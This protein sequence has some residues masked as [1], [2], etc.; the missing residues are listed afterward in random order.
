MQ[1]LEGSAGGAVP[2]VRVPRGAVRRVLAA[3]AGVCY[4]QCSWARAVVQCCCSPPVVPQD[5]AG[6]CVYISQCRTFSAPL[7]L[8]TS[9]VTYYLEATQYILFLNTVIEMPNVIVFCLIST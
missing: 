6:T 9:C 5:L 3:G 8:R 2:L 7:A 1:V 4:W